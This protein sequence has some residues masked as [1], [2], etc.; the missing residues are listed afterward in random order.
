MH[1][2]VL[3]VAIWLAAVP[4]WANVARPTPS[5]TMT[6]MKGLNTVPSARMGKAGDMRVGLGTGDPYLHA[7]LGLQ[8]IDPLYVQV[9]QTA[10]VSD[11]RD[12]ARRLYPGIDFKLKLLSETRTRPAIAL[13]MQSAIGHKRMAGEFIAASKRY[14]NFDFTA[15]LGWGRYGTAGHFDNPLQFLG[16]HF[17]KQR[18]LDGQLPNGPEDWF[19]GKS[20]GAFAGIEYFTPIKGLSLKLDYGADRYSAETAA[21]VF[22]DAPSPWS[23]GVNYRPLPWADFALGIQGT[24]TVMARINFNGMIQNW[25]DQ[26]RDAP[27]SQPLYSRVPYQSN[28]QMI[29]D[30]A[31][32]NGMRISHIAED[33]NAIQAHV[34]LDPALSTPYQAKRAAMFV[35]KHAQ[36]H[37][38]HIRI[39][40]IKHNVTTKTISFLRTDLEDLSNKRIS[41]NEVWQHTVLRPVK[42]PWLHQFTGRETVDSVFRSFKLTYDQQFSLSEEDAGHLRRTSVLA[43][44]HGVNN[45]RFGDM[46]A[47][48][49]VNVENNLD[50]VTFIRPRSFLPVRSDVD[51][52]ASKP[53]AVDRFYANY[54]YSPT[55]DIHLLGR[56]GYVEEMYGATG[57]EALYRPFGKRY[58]V[59]A[60]LYSAIRRNPYSW[61]NLG[62]TTD[63]LLTGHVNAWYD[64]PK[65][66][67]T[68]KASVGRYL[69]EDWGGTLSLDKTFD[70]GAS[71]GAFVTVTDAADD[72]LF[73]GITH[74]YHGVKLTLPLGGYKYTPQDTAITIRAEP[75]GRDTGQKLDLV[76]TLYDVTTPISLPHIAAHWDDIAD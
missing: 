62:F 9:R 74:A 32:L 18:P 3:V 12:N 58:A 45:S 66:D 15:G 68:I 38:E 39:T 64:V 33:G 73:G 28:K 65:H 6:G 75:F 27:L 16:A 56:S 2:W 31:E 40:P 48:M 34:F 49:R 4:V 43:G 63:T 21:G 24:D 1:T 42:R 17:D 67:M 53:I 41:S 35:A 44:F 76:D 55:S 8:I 61:L 20:I 47:T 7:F 57:V 72:D 29:T 71:L 19:T 25:P 51:A 60:E 13:G 37:I 26:Q 50:T 22:D 5:T 70:N 46:T 52:F 10:E 11:L 36:K 69:A 14:K 30:D 59:G 23:A 54:V